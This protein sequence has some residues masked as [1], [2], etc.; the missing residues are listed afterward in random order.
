VFGE[1]STCQAFSDINFVKI[2]YIGKMEVQTVIDRDQ[3]KIDPKEWP[4]TFLKDKGPNY[5][6]SEAPLD[7]PLAIFHSASKGSTLTPIQI[8]FL[9]MALSG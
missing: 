5:L 2:S 3:P 4:Y 8:E 1:T 9:K 6:I 7:G